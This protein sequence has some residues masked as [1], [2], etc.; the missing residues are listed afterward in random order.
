M[1]FRYH[2]SD[3]SN[4]GYRTTLAAITATD[5]MTN[6][7]ASTYFEGALTLTANLL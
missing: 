2:S 4:F 3:G 1:Q 7:S 5:K 6:H